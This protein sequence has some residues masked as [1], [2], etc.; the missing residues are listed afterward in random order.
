MTPGSLLE[1]ILNPGTDIK[2]G[3][4]TIN[5]T[6]KDGT[7]ISGTL[8]RK[9]NDAILIRDAEGTILSIPNEAVAKLENIPISLMP[10]G[11]TA[12]LRPDELVDLMSYLTNLGKT[13]G[14]IQ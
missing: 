14:S 12:S 9:T 8:H 10:K 4:E 11:L 5:L 6:Q 3:Y 7:I 2:Q 13:G 1:S